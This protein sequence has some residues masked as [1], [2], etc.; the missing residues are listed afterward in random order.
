MSAF[1]RSGSAT[2]AICFS[3]NPFATRRFVRLATFSGQVKAH[4]ADSL[5]RKG[6]RRPASRAARRACKTRGCLSCACPRLR[7]ADPRAGRGKGARRRVRSYVGLAAE[8][9]TGERDGRWHPS[10]RRGRDRSVGFPFRTELIAGFRWASGTVCDRPL[11]G[12]NEGEGR[13][14]GRLL[15][16]SVVGR[17]VFREDAGSRAER[18]VSARTFGGLCRMRLG[19]R[20]SHDLL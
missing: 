7:L 16:R 11:R 15:V 2:H 1:E 12:M 3:S 6:W 13:R 10:K 19:R 14:G 4:D 18:R 20:R 8:G 17:F 9:S 5:G